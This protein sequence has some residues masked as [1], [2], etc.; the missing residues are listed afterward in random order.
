MLCKVLDNEAMEAGIQK[1]TDL[2]IKEEYELGEVAVPVE[3]PAREKDNAETSSVS[4]ETSVGEN[5]V[6]KNAVTEKPQ[7]EIMFEE[8]K[9]RRHKRSHRKIEIVKEYRGLAK[10]KKK[11]E[12]DRLD[13]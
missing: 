8:R 10:P 2:N 11:K 1:F 5:L 12:E 9:Q 13:C 3:H 7:E 4:T 6:R